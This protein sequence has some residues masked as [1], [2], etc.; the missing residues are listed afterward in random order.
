[1]F[2]S[3]ITAANGTKTTGAATEAE[4]STLLARA[5]RKG[6]EVRATRT[7]GVVITRDVWNGGKTPAK[8]VMA[9]EPTTPVGELSQRMT[10]DLSVI[11]RANAHLVTEAQGSFARNIGRINAI[12]TSVSPAASAKYVERGWVVLGKPERATSN[13]FLSETRRPVRLSLAVRLALTA[14]DV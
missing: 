4:L 8:R 3:T 10:G 14:R 2:T 7:G 9:Y 6:Y 1:M 5:E 13:G 12:L 11:G